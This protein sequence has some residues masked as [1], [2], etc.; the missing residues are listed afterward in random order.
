M[1]SI[2]PYYALGTLTLALFIGLFS[3]CAPSF[4]KV[5]EEHKQDTG[6]NYLDCGTVENKFNCPATMPDGYQCLRAAFSGCE[7]AEL[8]I[9]GVTEEGDPIPS[10][11]LVESAG[12]ATCQITVFIDSSQDDW[13]GDYGDITQ[14]SCNTLQEPACSSWLSPGE[15]R[16]V[17]E[18]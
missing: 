1:A 4:E 17:D 11:W 2:K 5:V 12:G 14:K 9:D 13:K 15:C 18:W 7:P 6:L 8:R 3:G 16:T 10:V